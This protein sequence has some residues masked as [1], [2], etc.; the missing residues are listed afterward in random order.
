MKTVYKYPLSKNQHTELRLP[1]GAMLLHVDA[2]KDG[3][4]LWAE[5]ETETPEIEIRTI[6]VFGTGHAMPPYQ[7]FFLN[8]FLV[9]GGEFVFHAY[10][11]LKPEYTLQKND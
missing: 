1:M 4:F 3:V 8:T 5:I 7:R 2:Q 10:E 6:E 9:H 11:R